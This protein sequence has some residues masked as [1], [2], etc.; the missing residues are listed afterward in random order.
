[1]GSMGIHTPGG[2]TPLTASGLDATQFSGSTRPLENWQ[3]HK[4]WRTKRI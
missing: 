1:M 4:T 3:A 2:S